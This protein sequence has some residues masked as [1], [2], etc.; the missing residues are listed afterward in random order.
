M[1]VTEHHSAIVETC[2][3]IYVSITEMPEDLSSYQGIAPGM[4]FLVHYA[5]PTAL[6]FNMGQASRQPWFSSGSS[7]LKLSEWQHVGFTFDD[8]TK[9]FT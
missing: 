4:D 8:A 6:F 9:L 7:K 2:S 5:D 3:Y 1:F